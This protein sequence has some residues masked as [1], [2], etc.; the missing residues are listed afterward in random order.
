MRG[1]YVPT[2]VLPF[3]IPLA[4]VL[5]FAPKAGERVEQPPPD[6]PQSLKYLLLRKPLVGINIP[7][8]ISK[9]ALATIIR[10][11]LQLVGLTICKEDFQ[12]SPT[13]LQQTK[14]IAAWRALDLPVEGLRGIETNLLTRL[15][16]G[17]PVMIDEI[18]AVWNTFAMT[19]PVVHQMAHNFIRSHINA[20]YTGDQG[21]LINMWIQSNKERLKFFSAFEHQY[22]DYS[23]GRTSVPQPPGRENA[24]TKTASGRP[25]KRSEILER[26]RTLR[27]SPAQRKEREKKDL[28]EMRRRLRR[29]KSDDSIRSV[30]TVTPTTPAERRKSE[31]YQDHRQNR[32]TK[33][34]EANNEEPRREATRGRT[35]NILSDFFQYGKTRKTSPSRKRARKRRD[36]CAVPN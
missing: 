4:T 35:R 18:Q 12:T 7:Y 15:M 3:D 23:N 9:R 19:S 10:R 11:M 17:K 5:H 8:E 34:V 27:V 32:A 16:V 13:I 36:S 24:P 21:Q 33:D 14:L 20:D 30:E 25:R 26:N 28:E 31:G 6:L 1:Q 22:R 29:L 2:S